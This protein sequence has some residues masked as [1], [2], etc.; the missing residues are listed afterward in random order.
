MAD[1]PEYDPTRDDE[2][3]A[4]GARGGGDDDAQDWSLPGGP[5]DSPDERRRRLPGGA[6]RRTPMPIKNFPTTIKTLLCQPFLKK[7]ADCLQLQRAL[8]KPLS[9][10][11]L[12]DEL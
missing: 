12:Q 2:G 4:G 1:I 10:E 8:Q 9:L 7:G 5:T 3:A 11:P 6:R